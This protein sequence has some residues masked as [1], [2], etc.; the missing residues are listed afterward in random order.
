MDYHFSVGS[1]GYWLLSLCLFMCLFGNW[2]TNKFGTWAFIY[3]VLF[4]CFIIW[5]IFHLF[6]RI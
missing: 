4:P 3:F 1:I 2:V 5:V 6:V